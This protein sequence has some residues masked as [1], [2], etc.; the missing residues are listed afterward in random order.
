MKKILC[1]CLILMFG[2]ASLWAQKASRTLEAPGFSQNIY[3]KIH[4]EFG[5]HPSESA[6]QE[7][8]FNKFDQLTQNG[9]KLELSYEKE[10]PG[11]FHYHF[12]QTFKGKPVKDGEIKINMNSAFIATSALV[13][14]IESPGVE[15][16]SF[17]IP[18][19]EI[20][21]AIESEFSPDP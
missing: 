13:H 4:W 21:A 10:S 16:G 15:K 14:L 3:H 6:L 12:I 8:I 18:E 2:S 19:S 5:D 17:V 7:V 1:L 9:T 20:T 11:G